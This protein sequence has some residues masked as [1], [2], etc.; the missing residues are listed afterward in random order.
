MGGLYISFKVKE[1][2]ALLLL[3]EVGFKEIVNTF[4]YHVK[5]V[6]KYS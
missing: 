3:T 5:T 2:I 1:N 6:Y 4:H